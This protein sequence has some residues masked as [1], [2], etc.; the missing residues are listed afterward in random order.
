MDKISHALFLK[1]KDNP[2]VTLD[3]SFEDDRGAIH[4]IIDADMKSCVIIYSKK[5]SI[6]ANH[7]HKTDWRYCYVLDGQIEYHWRPTGESTDAQTIII[8]KGQCFFTPPLVDHA[9]IFTKDTTFLTLGRNPRDQKS[10]ESDIERI[11]LTS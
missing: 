10:Y 4:P 3:K 8:E 5:G 2:I 1:Y 7:F 6:R 9:M 11:N